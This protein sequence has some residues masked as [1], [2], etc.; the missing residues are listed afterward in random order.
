M[1]PPTEHLQALRAVAL[2]GEL[3]NA[4][5]GLTADGSAACVTVSLRLQPRRPER[6]WAQLWLLGAADAERGANGC[7]FSAAAARAVER[8]LAHARRHDGRLTLTGTALTADPAEV[9][10][11]R[12]ID[13]R[14]EGL[15]LQE[16][17]HTLQPGAL[18]AA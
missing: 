8:V 15:V 14:V 4:Y 18:V 3:V 7:L 13:A 2:R 11:L 10:H 6:V 5:P 16:P 9:L 17:A 1:N 12:L